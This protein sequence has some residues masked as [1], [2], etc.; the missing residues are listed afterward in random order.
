MKSLIGQPELMKELNRARALDILLEERVISRPQLAKRT[1]LSRA[2]IAILIDEL[3]RAGLVR[4]RGLGDSRGGRPPVMIEFNPHAALALG[5]RLRDHRWGIVLTDL[6]AEVVR[7][8]ET[9]LSDLSPATAVAALQAGVAQITQG[10]DRS[11]LLPAIGLGTPGLVDMAAG[12]VKT[13]V[14]VGWVDVP[15]RAMAEEALGM[16]VYVANRSKVGALAELWCGRE[17]NVQNLLYI[18]IG[19]GIAAGV[20]IQGQLY[21]GVNSSAGELGHVTILPDGPLCACGN[22]GCLQALSS[23][24]AI[25]NRARAQLRRGPDSL[26]LELTEG[27][28]ERIMAETVFAAAEQGDEVAQRVVDETAAYLGIAVANLVNLFNPAL[29]VLG[30]PVGQNGQVLLEPLRAEVQRRAMAYPL[31]AA[32]IVSSTLGPDAGAIGA[33]VL[34]LQHASELFFAHN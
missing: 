9:P 31:S 1:G 6:D 12:V 23:G 5:A 10:I 34:V 4:E 17:Q 32:R 33:A 26:L 8:L 22:R 2:T 28:P 29:I 27:H 19:T 7:H 14:D 13:A 24:P 11:R 25:A 21:M 15:I 3:L 16:G 30:G 18:A 20:V